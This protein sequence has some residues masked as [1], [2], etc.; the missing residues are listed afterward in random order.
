[1]I[2]AFVVGFY[3]QKDYGKG[4][5]HFSTHF[6]NFKKSNTE[7]GN[8]KHFKNYFSWGKD[9]EIVNNVWI[10]EGW[11]ISFLWFLV[12]SLILI[13]EMKGDQ[14]MLISCLFLITNIIIYA[15]LLE[16]F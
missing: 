10:G 4:I 15:C 1:M 7:N 9:W 3:N 11:A 5:V 2:S 8:Q 12:P 13:I 6:D 16:M 14:Y